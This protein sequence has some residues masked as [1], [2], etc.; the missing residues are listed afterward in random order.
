MSTTYIEMFTEM[1][2]MSSSLQDESNQL[3][4]VLDKTIGA[5]FDNHE[6]ILEQMNLLTANGNWLDCWGKDFGIPRKQDE[7]DDSY[8]ERIIF[9]KLEYLTSENLQNIYGLTL[10]VNINN[11]NPPNNTLTSDNQYIST[12]Y[13]SY[14][15]ESLKKIINN[16]FIIGD[17]IKWL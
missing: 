15:D 16:K 13:M 6:N 9:E 3:R 14:A 2:S 8:R 4:K 7:T 1:M 5:W 12:E 11:F 17:S 10:Y